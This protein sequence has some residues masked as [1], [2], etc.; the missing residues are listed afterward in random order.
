[1]AIGW[2]DRLALLVDKGIECAVGKAAGAWFDLVAAGLR[3]DIRFA[4]LLDGGTWLLDRGIGGG[5]HDAV[6]LS[7]D[8]WMK[9]G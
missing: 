1:M 4:W 9:F 5:N 3:G 7:V 2:G 6:L 8:E